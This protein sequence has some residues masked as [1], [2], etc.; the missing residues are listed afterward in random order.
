LAHQ[1]GLGSAFFGATLLAL[2][3]SLPEV[4][5]TVAAARRGR[6]ATSIS[7]IFGSNAFDVGLLFVADVLYRNG[8][9]LAHGG[10]SLVFMAALATGMTCIYLWGLMERE[11]RTVWRMGGDSFAVLI[12]YLGGVT[13]LYFIQ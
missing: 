11:N 10:S 1:T 5:T 13:V 8:S 7:N 2:A 6:Y 4:S 3:T 9:V 12:V